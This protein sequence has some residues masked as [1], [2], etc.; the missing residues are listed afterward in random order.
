MRTS[1]VALMGPT[2]RGAAISG[3]IEDWNP[4]GV[5]GRIEA[6]GTVALRVHFAATG[7]LLIVNVTAGKRQDAIPVHGLWARAKR[8]VPIIYR[9]GQTDLLTAFALRNI[10]L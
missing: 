1:D 5:S 8:S 7:Q 9:M 6:P 2:H 3:T 10:L 4:D